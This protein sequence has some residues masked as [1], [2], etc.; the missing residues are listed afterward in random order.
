M[1]FKYNTTNRDE[2]RK[3]KTQ[4]QIQRKTNQDPI[5]IQQLPQDHLQKEQGGQTCTIILAIVEETKIMH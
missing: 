4:R 3:I 5:H 1:V 2:E